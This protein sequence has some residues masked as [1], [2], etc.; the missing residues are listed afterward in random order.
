MIKEYKTIKEVV[1]PLMLVE[2]VEGVKYNELVE[3]LQQNGEV[4]SGKVLE[5]N[6]DKALVQ[7]FESSQGLKISSAKA[8]FLGRSL[9]LD[10]SEDMLGRVFDGMGR[11]RDAGTP[12]IA[13]KTLDVNGEPINPAARDYPNQFIQTGISAIDG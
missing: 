10:V 1:G 12:V 6:G 5:V 8:R 9:S 13:K 3:I 7:L 4:R 2:G 11:P